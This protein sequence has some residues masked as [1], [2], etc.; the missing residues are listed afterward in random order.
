[1]NNSAIDKL[2]EYH[3]AKFDGE[4]PPIVIKRLWRE[5]LEACERET[6]EKQGL[7]RFWPS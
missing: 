7:P 4:T 6:A 1:M 5:Y 3:R 2:T